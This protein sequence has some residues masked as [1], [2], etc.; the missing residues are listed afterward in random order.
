MDL[1]VNYLFAVLLWI[2]WCAL[3]SSLITITVTGYMKKKLGDQQFWLGYCYMEKG[4]RKLALG[5]YFRSILSDP[6]NTAP[7]KYGLLS[8]LPTRVFSLMEG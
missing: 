4:E 5:Q 8:L 7:W 1:P 6:F 2:L 3:H